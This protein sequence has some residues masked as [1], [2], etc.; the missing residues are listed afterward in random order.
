[1]TDLQYPFDAVPEPACLTEVAPG[2][3]WLRMPLPM[4]LDHINLYLLEDGDGWWIVDTGMGLDQT[5]ALWE[6][7]FS[8]AMQGKPVKAV[9]CTHMHPDHVGQAGWLCDKWR[10]PLY[11]SQGEYFAAR[12]FSTMTVDDVSWTT[13]RFFQNAGM[14]AGFIEQMK[15]HFRGFG[16]VAEKLPGAYHRLEDA[17][18]LTIGGVRWRVITGSGHSPE[19]ACLY[20]PALNV[21]L[22]G[23][24]VIP[25]ITSN[26]SVSSSEP[27]GNP[28]RSW[29]AS[30]EKFLDQL[31]ADALVLPAHNTPFYGLHDRL[32][33]LIQH[34]EDHL[35]ALEEACQEPKNAVELLPVLFKRE[36]DSN[37]IGMALGECVAHLNYLVQRG[38]LERTEDEHGCH[39]FLSVDQTLQ[40]RLRPG[41]HALDDLPM[42][43]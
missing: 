42:Q 12:V 17:D 30:H 29:L 8:G 41:D 28:L 31:P 34:H 15:K 39:Q 22:S 27:E 24:Q 3:H 32:R 18:Y 36:L 4:A 6:Q 5:Q 19:H 20:S 11:M 23:D 2:I 16:S 1:M 10:V 7:L 38:Q 35:L 33:F 9:V 26:V 14:D 43:V 21:L 37:I 25:R 13:E 40:Q